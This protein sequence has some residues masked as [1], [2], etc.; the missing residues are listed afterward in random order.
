MIGVSD[1]LG[2]V[3]FIVGLMDSILHFLVGQLKFGGNSNYRNTVR[4]DTIFLREGQG[5]GVA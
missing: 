3:D 1:T 5:C 4:D 2:T